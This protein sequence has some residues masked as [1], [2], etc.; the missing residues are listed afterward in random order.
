M[1]QGRVLK[2]CITFWLAVHCV[3][4]TTSRVFSVLGSG[5]QGRARPCSRC[6]A[7]EAIDASQE[8]RF[9]LARHGQ[10]TFN[11]EKRFQ[12]SLD[13]EPVLTEKGRAQA[14]DLGAWLNSL[15]G[16]EDDPRLVFTSPLLRA[17]QTLAEAKTVAKDL[18]D[19]A[20][21]L[22]ELR[23]IDL[24]EWEGQTQPEVR[25]SNPEGMRLWKEEAWNLY[26]GDGRLVVHD[27]WERAALAWSKMRAT[28][29]A[30]QNPAL[31]VA[32]GTLGKAL[33]S[34]AMGLPVQA[35]RRFALGNGEVVE[36]YWPHP[37]K[38]E[39]ARWRKRYPSMGPW[40]SANDEA[41]EFATS[42]ATESVDIA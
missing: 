6:V 4:P 26:L 27:L 22:A 38:Q 2:L 25:A 14:R 40:R 28:L 15:S 20:E 19:E 5:L 34:T 24:Y 30:G 41:A 32:H 1:R 35:F 16:T 36:V 7:R 29:S 10:T 18:P 39:G 9:L 23:E 13:D 8:H 12:G 37:E 21:A 42:G 17:R 11:A 31:I 3:L 33:L